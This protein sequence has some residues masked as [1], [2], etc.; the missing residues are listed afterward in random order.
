M[1]FGVKQKKTYVLQTLVFAQFT[2]KLSST[3]H[4][5]CFTKR[6]TTNLQEPIND[7]SG[8]VEGFLQQ[9]EAQVHLDQ[10]VIQDG[11]HARVDLQALQELWLHTE[12]HLQ[13]MH[14]VIDV[15]D[16]LAHQLGVVCILS[17]NVCNIGWQ[18]LLGKGHDITAGCL[19]G[20]IDH[21]F[22]RLQ[23]SQFLL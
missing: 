21:I 1:K 23:L 16:I 7:G 11:P 15:V 18:Q 20:R 9:V 2:L 12:L 19:H 6:V 13:L 8:E 5:S 14:V 22:H 17:V 4:V 3:G 10:P